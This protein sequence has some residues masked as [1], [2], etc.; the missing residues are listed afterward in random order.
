MANDPH[1]VYIAL[2]DARDAFSASYDEDTRFADAMCTT[3]ATSRATYTAWQ[4]EIAA[5]M[6]WLELPWYEHAMVEWQ[7]SERA[8]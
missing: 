8:A 4:A 5:T 3:P 2:Q 7:E 6:A 1:T